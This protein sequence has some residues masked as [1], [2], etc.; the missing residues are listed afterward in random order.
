LSIAS[1]C[2]LGVVLSFGNTWPPQQQLLG[3]LGVALV[4]GTL[5]LGIYKH[6]IKKPTLG[7]LVGLFLLGFYLFSSIAWNKPS[8]DRNG[9]VYLNNMGWWM[10]YSKM[11]MAALIA[12]MFCLAR[13]QRVALL[14]AFSGTAFLLP[15]ACTV[16]SI[17]LDS[18]TRVGAIRNVLTGQIINSSGLM[19][20]VA[21]LPVCYA[22]GICNKTIKTNQKNLIILLVI[23]SIASLIGYFYKSRSVFI[24]LYIIVFL[25][26]IFLFLLYTRRKIS[27]IK[28]SFFVLACIFV[29]LI[30]QKLE[31]PVNFEIFRDARFTIY[32]SSFIEQLLRDPLQHACVDPLLVAEGRLYIWFHNFFA[33]AHRLSGLWSFLSAVLLVGYIGIRVLQAA[34]KAPEGRVLLIVFIPVFL[35]LNTSVVPEGEFQ[36]ILLILLLGGCAESILREKRMHRDLENMPD[37]FLG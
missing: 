8:V 16:Y 10:D 14:F 15:I 7:M 30:L 3:N 22:A 12:G 11:S 29:S 37:K 1:L 25:M 13:N 4:L 18:E 6:G 33:D 9:I 17:Y 27:I 24:I 32:L 34:I 36:P 5:I 26:A 23:Y 2:L 21:F 19:S 20:L 31:C 28:I 35:I